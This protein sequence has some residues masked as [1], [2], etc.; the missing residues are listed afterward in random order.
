MGVTLRDT[1]RCGD[2]RVGLAVLS[3]AQIV[4]VAD[5]TAVVFSGAA[6]YSPGYKAIG[7]G[8]ADLGGE[9]IF[10]QTEWCATGS[11]GSAF[12]GEAVAKVDLAFTGSGGAIASG[13]ADFSAQSYIFTG[14]GGAALSGAALYSATYTPAAPTGGVSASGAAPFAVAYAFSGGGLAVAI[15][16]APFSITYAATGSG[17]LSSSGAALGVSVVYDN[18]PSTGGAAFDGSALFAPVF[19]AIG[20]GGLVASGEAV[21]YQSEWVGAVSGGAVFGGSVS[22]HLEIGF[23]ASGS[24][25]FSGAAD[26]LMVYPFTASGGAESSGEASDVSVTYS[27]IGSGGAESSGEA[28]ASIIYDNNPATGGA[29]FSGAAI[30]EIDL[31]FIASGSISSSGLAILTIVYTP[32]LS[33]GI[34][35]SGSISYVVVDYGNIPLQGGGLVASGEAITYTTIDT[36][37]LPVFLR[38]YDGDVRL[39]LSEDGAIIKIWGGQPEMEG[40]LSTAVHISLFTESDW[41]G[42]ALARKGEAIGSGFVDAMRAPL[43]NAARLDIEE[44]ARQ[45]LAWLTETGIAKSIEVSATIP[46]VGE[47]ALYLTIAQP[48]KAPSRFRYSVN[49]QNQHVAMEAA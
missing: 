44:A 26:A 24:S 30:A 6:P 19:S 7:A 28:L 8:G 32:S 1:A 46:A 35:A 27:A 18:A 25:E 20:S 5:V 21:G 37:G 3:K 45:A 42:N 43:T 15:T 11:G 29:S 23:V 12:S 17:G 39:S 48:D 13:E 16:S 41:W 36:K 9:A 22:I 38:T 4:A 10:R 33:G 2:S 47:L 40:G 31:V 14:S 34:T 49:W